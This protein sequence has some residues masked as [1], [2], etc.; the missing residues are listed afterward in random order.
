MLNYDDINKLFNEDD[1]IT[2]YLDTVYNIALRSHQQLSRFSVVMVRESQASNYFVR[3]KLIESNNNELCSYNLS[4]FNS[5]NQMIERSQQRIISDLHTVSANPRT[6]RLLAHGHRSGFSYPLVFKGKAIA[7][8]FFNSSALNYFDDLHV[9]NDMLILSTVIHS[10]LVRQLET[11]Q[12]LNISLNVALNMGHAKDPETKGHL[13]RMER[14]SSKLAYL[15][16][17]DKNIS[18]EFIRLIETYA[19]Y[20]DI[21]K[22]KIPDQVLFSTE[23]FTAKEREIMNGHCMH[24]IDIVNN[25]LQYFPHYLQESG[26]YQFLKNVILY[27]HERFD[28]LGYPL[29]LQGKQIPLE[30]RIIMTAD[31]FDALLSKRLYKDAWDMDEVIN[32]MQ[33]NAGTMFD[34]DCIAALIDNL[35]EFVQI[36]HQYQDD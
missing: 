24:G 13:T 17:E 4:N 11:Q 36:Y 3:D 32:F 16:A 34:P 33:A 20:H 2:T 26:E 10:L 9:Q 22:Y 1:D 21:G 28:G 30:A 6:L 14:Y 31:V 12:F 18:H 23:K 15:L 27:H 19:A 35:P 7:L 25:L 29:G 8:V 5:L